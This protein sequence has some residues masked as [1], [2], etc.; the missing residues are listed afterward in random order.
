M[1]GACLFLRLL[2]APDLFMLGYVG[3][4][5]WAVAYNVGHMTLTPI[6]IVLASYALGASVGVRIIILIRTRRECVSAG[7]LDACK[8]AARRK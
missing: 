6:A 2:F 1:S 4:E 7:S 8:L 3:T 5:G